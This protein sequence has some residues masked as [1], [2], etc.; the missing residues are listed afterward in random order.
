MV[1]RSTKYGNN[2]SSGLAEGAM[3]IKSFQVLNTNSVLQVLFFPFFFFLVSF[4]GGISFLYILSPI[5]SEPSIYIAQGVSLDA[6]PI[7]ALLE[8]VECAVSYEITVQRSFLH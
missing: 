4:L 1:K 3:Y 5:A 7:K 8:V 2:S 6:C